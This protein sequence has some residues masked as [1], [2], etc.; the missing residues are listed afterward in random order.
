[1]MDLSEYQFYQ[2]TLNLGFNINVN[3]D[4]NF[5]LMN[6]CFVYTKKV[7]YSLINCLTYY[8]IFIFIFVLLYSLL[9]IFIMISLYTEWDS[10]YTKYDSPH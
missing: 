1:M 5:I 4:F 10:L 8:F 9:D 6:I 2:P 7:I 3:V